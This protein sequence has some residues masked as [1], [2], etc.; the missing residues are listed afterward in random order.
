MLSEEAQCSVSTSHRAPLSLQAYCLHYASMRDLHQ[1]R[2]CE[3]A[4]L[5]IAPLQLRL[6][7]LL[8]H[9]L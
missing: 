7:M 1:K 8:G 2:I 6:N 3:T 4:P 9:A 5:A